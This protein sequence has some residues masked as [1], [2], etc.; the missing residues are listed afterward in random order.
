MF[1]V[2][3]LLALVSLGEWGLEGTLIVKKSLEGT[4]IVKKSIRSLV[5]E[6]ERTSALLIVFTNSF[7]LPSF[8]LLRSGSITCGL[9][10]KSPVPHR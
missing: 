8:K 1:V 6:M 9:S 3:L 5:L 2:A 4:L 7:C 10:L